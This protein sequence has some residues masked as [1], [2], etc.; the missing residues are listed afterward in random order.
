M[1]M[2]C[3][4]LFTTSFDGEQ[5]R[6]GERDFVD[7]SHPIVK[8]HPERFVA[9]TTDYRSQG[10][11]RSGSGRPSMTLEEELR[12]RREALA[13]ID[14]EEAE[15]VVRR[16]QP[17]AMDRFWA[18]VARQLADPGRER[19]DAASMALLDQLGAA[20]AATLAE[21]RDAVFGWLDE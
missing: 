17:D 5:L 14:R 10:R 21:K 15:R 1:M 18:D 7:D 4:T 20:P 9:A 2:R 11:T 3:R 16:S 6:L 13:Q 12:V 8:A 19:E